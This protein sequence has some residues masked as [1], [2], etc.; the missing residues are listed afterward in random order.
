MI[1]SLTPATLL[2]KQIN[3]TLMRA[4]SLNCIQLFR[5][6]RT[7]ACQAPL[8]WGFPGKSTGVGCH[9]L[10][11][12]TKVKTESEVTQSCQTLGDS[13]DGSLPGSS[14]HGVSQA[15]VLEWGVSTFSKESSKPRDQTQVSSTSGRFFIVR[16]TRE[17]YSFGLFECQ[18]I[19]TDLKKAR[20]YSKKAEIA[21]N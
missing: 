19:E 15:R 13:M 16:V 20:I 3:L 8:S 17:V 10:L 9:F 1:V 14:I 11:Q 6:L 2:G 12:C 18:I 7:V 4:K 21:A 5:T